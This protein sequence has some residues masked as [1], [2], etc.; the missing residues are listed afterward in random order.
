M[1]PFKFFLYSIFFVLGHIHGT[2]WVKLKKLETLVLGSD[3]KLRNGTKHE[4]ENE[5]IGKPLKGLEK[6]FNKF[7][8]EKL[9]G[10]NI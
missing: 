1:T 6:A 5:T 3:G 2:L 8:E 10:I 7:V 9:I 4:I